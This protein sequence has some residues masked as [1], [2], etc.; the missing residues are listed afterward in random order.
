[1]KKGA[2]VAF[3][4][5]AM[6]L[7]ASSALA[8][9]DRATTATPSGASSVVPSIT[10]NGPGLGLTPYKLKASEL[11]LLP[12]QTDTVT[13]GGTSMTES[14]PLLSSLL[15]LAGV[16]YNAACKNDELRYWIE[17]TSA[18]GSAAAVV[19]AGEI[20]TGFGNRPAILSIDENGQFLT[21]SGPRL[22]VPNDSGARDIEHV[23]TITIG[24][25]TAQLADVTPACASTSLVTAPAPGSIMVNGDVANP[26][27]Y[28]FA[29]LGA[30]SQVN[31]TDNF[32]SGSSATTDTESGPTLD[33]VVEAAQPKFLSCDPN[34]KLRF[35]VEVTSSEDGYA[36]VYSWAEIDPS[37]D[38][39]NALLSL[40]ENG[41]SQSNVGPRAT[42][43]GDV[44]GGRYVSGSAI[45]TVFRAPTE[46]RI[47]SCQTKK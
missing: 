19:T 44:K 32:L 16:Q 38:N 31:Q 37:L 5:T 7:V 45:V 14:G 40:T 27:T 29:Q 6:A 2:V 21:R 4:V 8:A 20:D 39:D 13:I 34:D 10:V 25:A 30:L 43:P 12:Q 28:T 11:A 26:T 46:T 17:A 42:A 18:N 3:V 1:M 15:A 24:R 23:S 41:V 33:S 22:I 36:S 9:S 35:Y 47:P